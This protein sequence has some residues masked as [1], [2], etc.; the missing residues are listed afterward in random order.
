MNEPR[1]YRVGSRTGGVEGV[2]TAAALLSLARAGALRSGDRIE[3]APGQW[4]SVAASPQ[5]RAA[6]SEWSGRLAAITST[7][8]SSALLG[9]RAVG[10]SL[11]RE[12]CGRASLLAL[13]AQHGDLEVG[14]AAAQ[15][16]VRDESDGLGTLARQVVE[17]RRRTESCSVDLDLARK[18]VV[19]ALTDSGWA[20]FVDAV[21]QIHPWGGVEALWRPEREGASGASLLGEPRIRTM[22][23]LEGSRVLPTSLRESIDAILA[24]GDSLDADD[25][26]EL[27]LG[28]HPI[29]DLDRLPSRALDVIRIASRIDLRGTALREVPS[30]LFEDKSY[31]ILAST[32]LRK[33]PEIRIRKA[34]RP[35]LDIDLEGTRVDRFPESWAGLR[36]CSVDM[37]GCPLHPRSL[38]WLPMCDRV[39]AR[40]CGLPDVEVLGSEPSELVLDDNRLT[41]VPE[42]LRDRMSRLQILDLSNNLITDLP[43]WIADA[44]KL[45]EIR[46]GQNL[47]TAIDF[48]IASMPRL[49]ELQLQSNRIDEITEDAFAGRRLRSIDLS[50]NQ[51]IS[52]PAILYPTQSI[53]LSGNPLEHLPIPLNDPAE[54]QVESW[55]QDDA[56]TETE[57]MSDDSGSNDDDEDTDEEVAHDGELELE[58]E[59]EVDGTEIGMEDAGDTVDEGDEPDDDGDGDGEGDAEDRWAEF[60]PFQSERNDWELHGVAIMASN[61]SIASLPAELLDLKISSLT[62]RENRQLRCVPVDILAMPSLME[63]DLAGC[64]ALE[65]TDAED[66]RC[67]AGWPAERRAAVDAG[68]RANDGDDGRCCSVDLGETGFR[69]VP[70]FLARASRRLRL[71]LHR[72]A[73]RVWPAGAVKPD[74]LESLDL[75]ATRIRSIEQVVSARNLEQLFLPEQAA[76]PK[77][78]ASCGR[79]DSLDL[80]GRPVH[81]YPTGLASLSA[82]KRLTIRGRALSEI[83]RFVGSLASLEHLRIEL[84]SISELPSFLLQCRALKSICVESPALCRIA[85]EVLALPSLEE[86][87]I[88]GGPELSLPDFPKGCSLESLTVDS[89]CMV[90]IPASIVRCASLNRIVLSG[91]RHAELPDEIGRMVHLQSIELPDNGV[92]QQVRGHLSSLL[93][94]TEIS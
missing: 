63:L 86:L 2:F 92:L 88:T 4:V 35:D 12:R 22:R 48:P 5:I 36:L 79:L 83:P 6:L 20:A 76:F 61:T 43:G 54:P 90:R 30:W 80:P 11:A 18:A 65:A 27:D 64:L 72:S 24:F 16:L 58:L 55:D 52:M 23:S 56:D 51:L 38:E 53:D 87:V 47:L 1:T 67:W 3:R 15:V 37:A 25:M 49:R 46:L 17:I 71:R 10:P 74:G 28:G 42:V 89:A 70:H 75:S 62:L 77:W 69:E 21:R 8:S 29:E 44:P 45:R 85:P 78:L 31:V 32:P 40:G 41:R 94:A 82:C 81:E 14:A 33:L 19:R 66:R 91:V 34:V 59:L 84:A 68:R 9:V 50:E 26:W 7:N 39:V 73:I 13:A 57:S 93:P 60:A